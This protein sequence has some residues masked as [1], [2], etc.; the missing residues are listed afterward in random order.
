[1]NFPYKPILSLNCHIYRM[2]R[3]RKVL[4]ICS[5][6]PVGMQRLPNVGLMLVHR[7]RRWANIR[8]PLGECVVFA[9]NWR[10]DSDGIAV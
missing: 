6:F 1:M 8:P 2:S 10:H 9:V 5:L 4:V 3:R 7:L